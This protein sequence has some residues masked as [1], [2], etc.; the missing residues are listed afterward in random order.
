V[1]L[2]TPFPATHTNLQTIASTTYFSSPNAFW[3]N[4]QLVPNGLLIL[5]NGDL[6]LLTAS[7]TFGPWHVVSDRLVC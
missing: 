2:W 5:P 1:Y 7:A 6:E 3:E 4:S